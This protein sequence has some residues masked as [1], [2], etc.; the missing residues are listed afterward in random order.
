VDAPVETVPPA[1]S[2]PGESSSDDSVTRDQLLARY[3]EAKLALV[4]VLPAVAFEEGHIPG[5]L[6]LPVDDVVA[7]APA[8][9]P[10]KSQEIVVY[11][12]GF[13]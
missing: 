9:L 4:N 11:C 3:G 13:T 10:D 6:S 1:P 12:G 2:G 5:S 8:L 7:R